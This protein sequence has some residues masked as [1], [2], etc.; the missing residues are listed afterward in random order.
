MVDNATFPRPSQRLPTTTSEWLRFLLTRVRRAAR[1]RANPEKTRPG[2]SFA[3]WRY[4]ADPPAD[5]PTVAPPRYEPDPGRGFPARDP[6]AGTR[7]QCRLL[8]RRRQLTAWQGTLAVD[9][10]RAE[11]GTPAHRHSHPRRRPV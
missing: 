4:S 5:C 7:H 1:R 8:R 6:N 3:E 11:E 10:I 9:S 2:S